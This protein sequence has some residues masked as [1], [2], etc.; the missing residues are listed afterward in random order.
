[1]A[2]DPNRLIMERRFNADPDDAAAAITY[3]R[4]Y[5]YDPGGNR[6][7]MRESQVGP[8]PAQ[9]VPVAVTRYN[10]HTTVL[11][12]TGSVLV[13]P[14]TPVGGSPTQLN[15]GGGGRNQLYSAQRYFVN[16]PNRVEVTRYGYGLAVNEDQRAVTFRGKKEWRRGS[17]GTW[18]VRRVESTYFNYRKEQVEKI[19]SNTVDYCPNLPECGSC[20]EPCAVTTHTAYAEFNA[21]DVFG[22]R[23]ASIHC[24]EPWSGSE[25]FYPCKWQTTMY[26]YDGLSQNVLAVRRSPVL[27]LVTVVPDRFLSTFTYGPL[28]IVT[29]TEEFGNPDP[30]DNV[31]HYY[32]ADAMGGHAGM[33]VDHDSDPRSS[34]MLQSQVFD[35]FGNRQAGS[36]DAAAEYA[37]RGTE[38]SET[39]AGPN[40]VLM[41]ARHY[42]PELGRFLQ[43]DTLPMASMTTQG[44]NRYIY[45]END[46]VNFTDP[47]GS[48]AVPNAFSHAFF[49]GGL[50]G[51][52]YASYM[53]DPAS[54]P[55]SRKAFK[56]IFGLPV[57]WGVSCLIK[58]WLQ[59]EGNPLLWE[60]MHGG[61]VTSLNPLIPPIGFFSGYSTGVLSYAIWSLFDS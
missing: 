47:F 41:Q 33:L 21:Y 20:D 25:T 39:D 29:R 26:D 51:A 7:V 45:C 59:S 1:L 5:W 30:A 61:S 40:L 54:H 3:K 50:L 48:V 31:D 18:F 28:G 10:Y 57:R 11:E 24:D 4:E 44:M 9:D 58:R 46:P 22:R 53:L 55:W 8:T 27:D 14:G 2:Q 60:L 43:E 19:D 56:Y 52:M 6:L 12:E 49:F 13:Q 38:G 23:V 36:I 37:W 15:Y 17:G 32:L 34:R 16:D 35:A 42:D